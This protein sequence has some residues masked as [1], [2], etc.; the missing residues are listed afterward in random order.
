[1][2]AVSKPRINITL[3]K[4]TVG[5]LTKL[6]KKSPDKK[7]VSSVAREL[8]LEALELREDM[9]LSKLAESRKGQ[10]RISHENAWK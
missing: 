10:Q 3:E 7:S 6:A 8:I 5:I 2:H 1:M 9:Y 4:S